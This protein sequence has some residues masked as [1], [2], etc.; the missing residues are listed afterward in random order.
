[1]L[2]KGTTIRTMFSKLS[3]ALPL[4]SSILNK[5]METIKRN[6]VYAKITLLLKMSYKTY[7]DNFI[8]TVIF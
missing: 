8:I 3:I 7:L 5:L 1:M 2:I 6:S 4:F